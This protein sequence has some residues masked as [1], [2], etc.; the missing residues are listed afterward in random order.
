MRTHQKLFGWLYGASD[1][2]ARGDALDAQ[3]AQMNRDALDSG[4]WS[5]DQFNQAE[6]NREAGLTGD[7]AE[8]ID[9]EFY[10]GLNEGWNNVLNAPGKAVGAIGDASGS[11]LGG[12][13]KNIP[14]WA[15]VGGAIALFVW[16]GGLALLRGRFARLGRIG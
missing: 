16:M 5:E 15:W 1:E 7:V 12:V 11:L 6:A 13:L 4:R 9:G 8:S 10:T 2:Q 3:L 14:W